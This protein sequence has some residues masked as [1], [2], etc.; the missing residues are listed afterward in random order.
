[1]N[2]VKRFPI[3]G[4]GASAG[5]VEALEGF[6]GGMPAKP[7]LALV[8]ITHLSPERESKLHEV[9]ARYT[10]LPV[11][12]A[13]DG[14]VVE[15][16][17]VYV[18]PADA[19]LSIANG[20]L[21]IGRLSAPRRAR[22]PID[23]FFTAL[24][25]DQAEHAAGV[26]LSGG[27]GDGTLGVK[28]I[29]EHGGLTLAQVSDGRG[30]GYPS[31]PDSAIST[32]LVDFAIPVSE[33]GAK[34]VEFGRSIDLLDDLVGPGRA[35]QT[36]EQAWPEIYLLLRNQI[37]HDFS[38]YKTKTFMRRVQ[39]RMQVNQL[40]TVD[41]Y[42]ERLRQDSKEVSALFRDLLIN[43][44]NFFRDADAFES[45][46]RLVIP[47]LFEQRGADDV[48]RVWVPGCSTG[49]E[50]FSIGILMR[51][52]MDTL[53]AVPRVQIFA[54]D[55]DDRAL[56][57]ARAAR[58]PGPLLE[59]VSP[60]RRQRF[61][62]PDGGSYVVVKEVR[63]L[64]VFSPHS[65]IRDPP[66][67]RIDLVSCRNL[68]I[69][70]GVDIQ[71]QVVPTF[72]YALRP[73][74]YLFL[75]SAENV[76]QFDDLFLPLEKK[77]RLFRR[78]SDV[79]TSLRMPLLLGT[80]RPGIGAELTARRAGLGALG[81]RQAAESHVLER[82]AP[83]HVLVNHSGDV[84]FFSARTGKYLEAPLGVPTRQILTMARKGLRL[85]LRTLFR[86]AVESGQTVT[87]E[88]VPVEAEDGRVQLVTITIEPLGDYQGS[89]TGGTNGS[90]PAT[91]TG[92]TNGSAAGSDNA[93]AVAGEPLFL[94]LFNDQGPVLSREEAVNRSGVAQGGATVQ[95]ERELRETRDRLQSIIEEYETAVEELK[96][97]NEELVSV[98][99]EMQ[100]TNEELE[101]SKEELQSVNE[102]L[103]TVNSELSG[104]V[105]ALDQANND[106]QNLFESTDVA[107][108][109][110]DH[111]LVIRSFTPAV[112]RIFN[113]LPG[114]RGRPITDLSSRFSLPGMAEDIAQVFA[115]RSAIERRVSDEQSAAH[116]LLRLAPYHDSEQHVRGVVVTF[117]DVSELI[118][119]DARQQLLIEELQHRTRNLLAIVQSIARQ[120]MG[121][122]VEM[123]A[124]LARL[125]ALSRVQ[126]L[127]GRAG[128]DQVEIGDIVRLELEALGSLTAGKVVT[129]GEAMS[130]GLENV[131]TFGLV[132]HELATNAMKY[133][134][135][136]DQ[137]GHLEIA[138]W[139]E[140]KTPTRNALIVLEWRET[141]APEPPD[142]SRR[143]FGRRLIEQALA[144]TLQAKTEFAFRPDGVFCRIEMPLPSRPGAAAQLRGA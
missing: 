76:S 98:N 117:L 107:A 45:L 103:H 93:S 24:A 21:Q 121:D 73:D 17:H 142:T 67:S 119:A 126:S 28:A 82:F 127:L 104:K 31:M 37:G 40:A 8:I 132:L 39:R 87:R 2:D 75:G 95:M 110:L 116:Y 65:V 89:A 64:C 11:H 59:S 118:R 13:E 35:D 101:A 83:P 112:A 68:L 86:E 97:S 18:L 54:T 140:A 26:V 120:T 6:F 80:L 56:T 96:S 63:D 12:V 130:L 27:D 15:Q 62:I 129:R 32:G 3:V 91:T 71:N 14:R 137:P 70:F 9:I 100:S 69:Y 4:V 44:T 128:N 81:M 5:G 55:I 72:H 113:I 29:K 111:D 46:E 123:D 34:L 19:V 66:F 48:V 134:A 122:G 109:F 144:Y 41:G 20:R 30:P 102:E 139:L 1:M 85:D 106:L 51:E 23:I 38:G 77:H 16:D 88:S 84:V 79:S 94:I 36:L 60:E 42:I 125:S 136:R 78:R 141:G 138:W 52:Y 74:G 25:I 22:K 105:E 7:G 133:G 131:Q 115:G 114:D 49:E 61:F 143:G 43:V 50:V 92:A 10:E 33:M 108:I 124:F 57:V 90:A 135:L 47:N 99:E 58:Y 53:T